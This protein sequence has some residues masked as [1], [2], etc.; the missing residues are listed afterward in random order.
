METEKD[1][2]ITHFT[3]VGSGIKAIKIIALVVIGISLIVTTLV[4]IIA[5]NT[6]SNLRESILVMDG[7]GSINRTKAYNIDKVRVIEYRAGAQDFFQFWFEHNANSFKERCENALQ[8]VGNTSKELRE[9]YVREKRLMQ[10]RKYNLDV[11]CALT[12][13]VEINMNTYPYTG[14]MEGIQTIDDG[15]NLLYVTIK[16]TFTIRDFGTRVAKNEHAIQIND[17]VYTEEKVKQE[18]YNNN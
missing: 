12:K 1:N 13:P 16:V 4:S 7:A 5:I 3:A 17:V 11:K 8:L 14:Y 10:I 15:T 6:V 9:R 2:L 18:K